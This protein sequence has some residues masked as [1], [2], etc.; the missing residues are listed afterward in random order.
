[1]T[2]PFTRSL[3]SRRT[4]LGGLT[5]G[6]AL[7]LAGC[8]GGSSTP[9][10]PPAPTGSEVIGKTNVDVYAWTNGPTIDANFKKRV[11]LF[12][13]EFDGKYTAKITFLPYDQYWQKIQ[14]QYAAQK[15]FDI[16][17][18]DVQA[19]AHYKKGLIFNEQPVIDS[20]PM[21]DTAA[22]PTKLYDPWRFDGTNLFCVPENIQS[23][24]LFYNKTHFDD[25]GLDYPNATWTWDQVIETAP[26]LQKTSGSKV[27]RWGLDIGDYG[28]W[29]GIQTLAWA[30]GTAFVDKP[31]EPTAFQLTDPNN[32][33]AFKFVQDLM[34]DKHVAPRPDERASIGQQNGGF[35]SGAYSMMPGGTWNIASYQQMKDDWAMTALPLYQG[36]SVQPYFLGGWV[37]PKKS[38]AL[39][40][41][42]AFATWSA[43]TFQTQM[44]QDHD[45]IPL[46]NAARESDAMLK[47]MPDGFKEAMKGLTDARIGDF[48][49]ANMQQIFNEVFGTNVTQLLANKATPEAVAQTMQA[50]ATKLL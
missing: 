3:I 36:K 7:A 13:K 34:W 1:M 40:A 32:V 17:Y 35:Q 43:T 46:Q 18:W 29:W 14:L 20:T 28:V 41:A 48:Y 16:Y 25:A 11:E 44:A 9:A 10:N 39:S 6:S 15:P 38:A 30:A 47:G 12:N 24:A 42:Q 37:V 5:A 21:V 45:W 2:T 19:Y 23:M 31:L 22:Y 26:K 4:L 33:A 27:T 50:A 49:T 8:S